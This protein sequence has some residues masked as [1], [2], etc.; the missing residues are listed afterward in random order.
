MFEA[1]ADPAAIF[2]LA[3]AVFLVSPFISRLVRLPVL[4]VTILLGAVLGPGTLGILERDAT[5][6]LFGTVG[7]LYLV[8]IAGLELDLQGFNQYRRRSII[9]GLLSFSIPSAL[10]L[11]FAPMF[12]FDLSASLLICGI[13]ASHTL[14]T[15]PIASRLGIA[16]DGAVTTVVGGSLLTDTLSL[17]LLAIVSNMVSGTLSPIF[18]LRFVGLMALYVTGVVFTIPRMGRWFFNNTDSEASTNYHFLLLALFTSAFLAQ[19]AGAEAIIGAFLAGLTLNRLVPNRSTMM[20][21]VK[22]F[23]GAFF[24]PFFLLSVGLIVDFRVLASLEVLTITA[25][26]SGLVIIGKGSAALISARIFGFNFLR[27]RLMA[28][29]SIPQAAATLAVTFVGLE[30]GLFDTAV[31]NAVIGLIVVSILFSSL[32][33]E[34][35]ARQVAMS[36]GDS[37]QSPVETLQRVLVPMANPAT[38]E[39]LLE[40]AFLLRRRSDEEF[41]YPLA[42]IRDDGASSSRAAQAERILAHAVVQAAEAEAPVQPITRIANNVASGIVQAARENRITD[43]IIGW[44]RP[45]A[46]SGT[47]FGSVIDRVLAASDQQV[48][49]CRLKHSVSTSKRLIVVLPPMVDASPGF[50]NAI[51]TLKQL[52]SQLGLPLDILAVESDPDKLRERIAEIDGDAVVEITRVDGWA[53][54]MMR[55]RQAVTSEDLLVIVSSRPGTLAHS[56]TLDRL[57]SWCA[58]QELS[59]IVLYLNEQL[60]AAR[61][62]AN[63]RSDGLPKLLSDKRLFFGLTTRTLAESVEVMLRDTFDLNDP[64]IQYAKRALLEDDIGF[65]KEHLPQ[66]VIMHARSRAVKKPVAF[67]GVH[68]AGVSDAEGE[69]VHGM[70]ILLSPIRLSLQEH[71]TL[72]SELTYALAR[73]QGAQALRQVDSL[74]ALREWFNA[75]SPPTPITDS[76]EPSGSE[77]ELAS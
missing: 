33:V 76:D 46:A 23:G 50:F 71:L 62:A 36:Q 22:F 19:L 67:F 61:L 30:L 18:W 14:L 52:S 63:R 41:L 32:L 60:L 77:L 37:E 66:M 4:V 15:Y 12:G 29:L 24:I 17:S 40:V 53:T 49:V 21:R 43:I 70:M 28:G 51:S 27:G 59:F 55:L 69:T 39:A 35:T 3:A 8:F 5:L 25:L 45:G 68:P 26:L 16:Q 42:V 64:D 31:V 73:A 38:S 48:L 75:E 58:Q 6:S 56:A 74:P 65:A 1:T 10:T 72:L 9:F 13:V 44:N 7:L 2:A 11:V 54:L 57:P 47:V 20:T 34:R